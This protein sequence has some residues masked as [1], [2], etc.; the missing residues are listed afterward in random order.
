MSG[1]VIGKPKSDSIH[2]PLSSTPSRLRP[3]PSHSLPSSPNPSNAGP[4][5]ITTTG[6]WEGMVCPIC[7]ITTNNLMDL[8]KHLD[9]EHA[10]EDIPQ[11]IFNWFKQAPKKLLTPLSNSLKNTNNF[12]KL[13]RLTT[14]SPTIHQMDQFMES[15]ESQSKI[16]QAHWERGYEGMECCQIGCTKS[17][18]LLNGKINC[19]K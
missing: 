4:S 13:Q 14:G 1:R 12:Q 19:R 7:Q 15:S 8:N 10:E 5:A 17:L 16:S 3:T 2:E 18:G 6:S 11:V 9:Q